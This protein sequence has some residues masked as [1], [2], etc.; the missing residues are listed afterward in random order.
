MVDILMANNQFLNTEVLFNILAP[1]V[2]ESHITLGCSKSINKSNEI[3]LGF[4]YAPA[5]TL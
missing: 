5:N 1:A 2:V 3:I 4:M